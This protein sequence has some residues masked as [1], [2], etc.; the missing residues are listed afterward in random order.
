MD[1]QEGNVTYCTRDDSCGERSFKLAAYRVPP[2][3]YS[4]GQHLQVHAS[5]DGSNVTFRVTE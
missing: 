3:F 4:E 1:F 2:L 5:M